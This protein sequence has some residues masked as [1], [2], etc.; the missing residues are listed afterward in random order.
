MCLIVWCDVV[1]ECEPPLARRPRQVAVWVLA[2]V[3]DGLGG[4]RDA[5]R[6]RRAVRL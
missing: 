5:R 1:A 6:F 4:Q 3:V 2:A